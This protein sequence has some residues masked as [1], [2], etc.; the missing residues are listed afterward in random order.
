MAWSFTADTDFQQELSQELEN[1]KT[2]FATCVTN[3]YS[4]IDSMGSSGDWKGPDYDAFKQ[5]CEGFHS[6]L[7]DLGDTFLMFKKH[8]DRV[9]TG[10]DA[11]ATELID[12][13]N[14]ITT[15][16]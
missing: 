14:N 5:T 1:A 2:K 16:S 12:I 6:A 15:K 9:Q 3:M 10:T 4:E 11:L 13:V 8:Y 7:D